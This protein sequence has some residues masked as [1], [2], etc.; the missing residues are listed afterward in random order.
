MLLPL[1]CIPSRPMSCNALTERCQSS[2]VR[3]VP[4]R[5]QFTVADGESP[6]TYAVKVYFGA[7]HP[8]EGGG[9]ELRADVRMSEDRPIVIGIG[10]SRWP[11]IRKGLQPLSPRDF[12]RLPIATFMEQAREAVAFRRE[13]EQGEIKAPGDFTERLRRA[14][15]PRAKGRVKG[16]RF[17]RD[18]A[19]AYKDEVRRGTPNPGAALAKRMGED[20]A[21]L[22]VWISRMRHEKG[23]L[24]DPEEQ[25]GKR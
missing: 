14:R 21:K 16:E 9:Y 23:L 18:L 24:P 22:R 19:E 25:R 13:Q 5:W 20:P 17:W 7:K 4:K 1:R 3:R 11:E 2:S 12:Q 15:A 10:V 8:L 6:D